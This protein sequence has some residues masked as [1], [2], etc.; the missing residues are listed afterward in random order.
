MRR[1]VAVASIACGLALIAVP[2][3]TSL[4]ERT[5]GAERTF[6]AMRETVSEPGIAQARRNFGVVSAAG[7]EVRSE[8]VPGLA[9]RLGIGERDLL[10]LLANDFP[11]IARGVER[12]PAYLE[13]VGPTIDAL[14]AN[15][16]AFEN[17]DSL[18]GAG[19]PITAS[20]WLILLLGGGLVGAG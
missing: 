6:D 16:D 8:L 2:F 1:V 7:A 20:P 3:A 17:A 12:I 11:D 10:A 5:R 15:R 19:L 9:R 18:P 4:F 14:D 13:F